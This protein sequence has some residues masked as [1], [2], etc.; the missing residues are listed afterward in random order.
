[1]SG[2][3]VVLLEQLED[4]PVSIVHFVEITGLACLFKSDYEISVDV[5]YLAGGGTSAAV[6]W[7]SECGDVFTGLQM[8]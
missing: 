7:T 1:M 3:K 4:D 2:D 8:S 5:Q 6:E